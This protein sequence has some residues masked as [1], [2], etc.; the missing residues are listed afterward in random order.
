MYPIGV[1]YAGKTLHW[2]LV[3]VKIMKLPSHSFVFYNICLPR[4]GE[5]RGSGPDTGPVLA[6][7][8]AAPRYIYIYIYIYR[9]DNIIDCICQQT[10]RRDCEARGV[11]EGESKLTRN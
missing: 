4:H 7:A 6:P 1:H 10:H 11:G 5:R 9:S 8:Q 3:P 2:Q